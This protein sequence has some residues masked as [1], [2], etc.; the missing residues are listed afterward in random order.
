M[1][2]AFNIAGTPVSVQE[3]VKN[4]FGVINSGKPYLQAA[5]FTFGRED[6]IPHMFHE[7][8]KDL[9]LQLPGKLSIFKYTLKGILKWMETTTATWPW[10][11]LRLYAE[12]MRPNGR[13]LL[14][15]QKKVCTCVNACGTELY[16]QLKQ[17]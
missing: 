1:D 11:W 7:L 2:A 12:M 3:F 5:V 14:L 15:L 13:K 16:A 8:I 6:L 10:R 4:T 17:K 9:S